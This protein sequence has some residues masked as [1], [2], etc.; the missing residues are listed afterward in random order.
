MNLAVGNQANFL[1]LHFSKAPV[2]SLRLFTRFICLC[3]RN[4][5]ILLQIDS[6]VLC[7]D[8]RFTNAVTMN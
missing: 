4:Q 5:G 7:N 8:I 6:P 2:I 1:L 3:L